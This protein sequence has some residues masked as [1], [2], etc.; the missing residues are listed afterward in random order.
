VEK[1]E[2]EDE[3]RKDA[4]FAVQ[5]VEFKELGATEADAAVFKALAGT[6]HGERVVALL[7]NAKDV[8]SKS[9]HL[10]SLGA[11]GQADGGQP[12]AMEQLKA[13]A[14]KIQTDEGVTAQQAMVLAATRNPK[15]VG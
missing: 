12:T 9:A 10:E 7:T 11:D 8:M 5:A 15:L 13:I 14:K 2:A 3:A 6:A 1:F 4:H